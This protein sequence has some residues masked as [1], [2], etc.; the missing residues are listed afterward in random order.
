MAHNE[1]GRFD[2]YERPGQGF[3][4]LIMKARQA[5]REE[6]EGQIAEGDPSSEI[7]RELD[8]HYGRHKPDREVR[9]FICSGHEYVQ[10]RDKSAIEDTEKEC[11]G[12][13]GRVTA[14]WLSELLE[15]YRGRG[16]QGEAIEHAKEMSILLEYEGSE[17][18]NKQTDGRE[19]FETTAHKSSSTEGAT[20][21]TEPLTSEPMEIID[22]RN[23]AKAEGTEGLKEQSIPAVIT[24]PG[25][26]DCWLWTGK[27]SGIVLKATLD[28]GIG[29]LTQDKQD[30]GKAVTA[31]QRGEASELGDLNYRPA[32]IHNRLVARNT[33]WKLTQLI[34]VGFMESDMLEELPGGSSEKDSRLHKLLQDSKCSEEEHNVPADGEE[35][36]EILSQRKDKLQRLRTGQEQAGTEAETSGESTVMVVVGARAKPGGLT[37]GFTCTSGVMVILFLARHVD[38]TPSSPSRA[39]IS[40]DQLAD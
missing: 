22:N 12:A 14:E 1:T 16:A 38:T 7:E 21:L 39:M 23:S 28:E 20:P 11:F 18:A 4:E 8:K 37:S 13:D 32:F 3:L 6:E 25:S 24:E 34:L 19:I 10:I 36:R 35:N 27:G 5:Y 31:Q 26:Q 9:N 2:S 30:K 15:A 17:R 33:A 40:H 29:T